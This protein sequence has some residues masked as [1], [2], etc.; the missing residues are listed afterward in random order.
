[1]ANKEVVTNANPVLPNRQNKPHDSKLA[2]LT[3]VSLVLGLITLLSLAM[4]LSARKGDDMMEKNTGDE[5]VVVEDKMEKDE[6]ALPD[7]DELGRQQLLQDLDD[8]NID[9]VV[10]TYTDE[11]F[12]AEL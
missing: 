12:D 10:N 11:A 2:L 7:N 8:L 9:E 5:Q 1:M 6:N 3:I 4:V